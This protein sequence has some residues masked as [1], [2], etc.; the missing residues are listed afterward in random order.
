MAEAK[1]GLILGLDAMVPN[2]TERFLGEG[3]LPNLLRMVERG[4]FTRVRPV[5]PAQTPSNWDTI[6]TGATPG[7]HGVVQWGSHIPGEPV[8]EYHRQEAFNAGLCR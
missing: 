5:I 6:A 4:C 1:R 7:T 3:V 8:W 2:I